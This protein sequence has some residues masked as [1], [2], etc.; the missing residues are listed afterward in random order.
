MGMRFFRWA[1]FC[2]ALRT[3]WPF[4]LLVLGFVLAFALAWAG[5]HH[6]GTV[7]LGDGWRY[8]GTWLQVFGLLAAGEGLRELRRYFK[9]PSLRSVATTWLRQLLSAFGPPTTHVVGASIA[10]SSWL[11]AHARAVLGPRPDLPIPERLAAAEKLITDLQ[12]E[13]GQV[14]ERLRSQ[15]AEV[16]QAIQEESR[17]REI[18]DAKVSRSV[19]D[20]G[21]G[22][23]P[24]AFVGLVWLLVGVVC[25]SIPP[26]LA[27]LAAWFGALWRLA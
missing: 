24:V 12:V 16:T 17:T 6:A 25:T 4:H 23:F 1:V 14:D 7:Q 5:L 22:G 18:G 20:V 3:A 19:E 10:E 9:R 26:E 13:L 11:T 21:V 2:N 27:R 15:I 8:A